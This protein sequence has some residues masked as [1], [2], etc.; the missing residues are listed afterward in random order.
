MLEEAVSWGGWEARDAQSRMRVSNQGGA[1]GGPIFQVKQTKQRSCGCSHEPVSH[2]MDWSLWW[3][4]VV[5]MENSPLPTPAAWSIRLTSAWLP[6]HVQVLLSML[7]R[8]VGLGKQWTQHLSPTNDGSGPTSPQSI[9]VSGLLRLNIKKVRPWSFCKTAGLGVCV[10]PNHSPTQNPCLLILQTQKS[11]NSERKGSPENYTLSLSHL[12]REHRNYTYWGQTELFIGVALWLQE[13]RGSGKPT[14]KSWVLLQ[15]CIGH[16]LLLRELMSRQTWIY[17]FPW[18]PPFP[19][20]WAPPPTLFPCLTVTYWLTS[21]GSCSRQGFWNLVSFLWKT[22]FWSSLLAW[23]CCFF[24]KIN[25]LKLALTRKLEPS[26][27]FFFLFLTW[28]LNV[29]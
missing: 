27:V 19:F 23:S 13:G 1:G 29:L 28:S 9:W 21:P 3:F 8:W 6:P 20:Y 17:L 12:M 4:M 2:F 24:D 25:H 22:V 11:H 16:C 5:V 18:W 14:Y 15:P 10:S 7:W 26:S